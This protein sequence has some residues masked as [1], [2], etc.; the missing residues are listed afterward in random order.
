VTELTCREA[1]RMGGTAVLERYGTEYFRRIG[2]LAR[3]DP[4]KQ[5]SRALAGGATTRARY[6][7]G[8]Y[9]AIGRLGGAAVLERYGTDHY[10]A[11]GR[12]GQARRRRDREAA[13]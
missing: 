2:A 6:G 7:A 13:R 3:R 8:H 9:E 4:D 5:R 10:R 11:L 1:G 12:L